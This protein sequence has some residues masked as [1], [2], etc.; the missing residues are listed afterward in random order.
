[1]AVLIIFLHTTIYALIIN[2]STNINQTKNSHRRTY[3]R[4]RTNKSLLTLA[5]NNN[6]SNRS[7]T[8]TTL[9]RCISEESNWNKQNTSQ[10]LIALSYAIGLPTRY[11]YDTGR[12][13][14]G[15][16]ETGKYGKKMNGNRND[17]LVGKR[18]QRKYVRL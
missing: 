6:N 12:Q 15:Y 11:T 7:E 18:R 3:E 9:R 1:M 8:D 17:K 5:I 14:K 13:V 10:I 4:T 16:G 2:I